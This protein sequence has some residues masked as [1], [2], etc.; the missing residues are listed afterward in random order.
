MISMNIT[1]HT[2]LSFSKEGDAAQAFPQNTSPALMQNTL[3]LS[4]AA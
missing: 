1:N 4:D 3:P 2:C